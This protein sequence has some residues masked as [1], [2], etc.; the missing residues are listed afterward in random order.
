MVRRMVKC[1]RTQGMGHYASSGGR[2]RGSEKTIGISCT[3]FHITIYTPNTWLHFVCTND[4]I[5]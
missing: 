2:L 3:K 1:E 4:N 5:V